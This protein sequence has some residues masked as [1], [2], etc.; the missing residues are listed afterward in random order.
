MYM[1]RNKGLTA[2]LLRF[3]VDISKW[4]FRT[5]CGHVDIQTVYAAD[6]QAKLCLISRLSCERAGTRCA[7]IRNLVLYPHPLTLSVFSPHRLNVRGINDDGHVANFVETEQ[8]IFVDKSVASY[9]QVRGLVPLFWDQPGIQTSGMSRIKFSRGY[10]CSQPVFERHFEW[11]LL[12][13][14]P[15]LC[16]NLLGTRDYELTLTS[17]FQEHL[18]QLSTVSERGEGGYVGG[19]GYA[20]G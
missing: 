18:N 3:G 6:K 5:M 7:L 1:C 15:I 10:H 4:L 19:A 11:C 13:Y 16:L 8:A 9:V 12:H 17:A 14:G 2:Y 20:C